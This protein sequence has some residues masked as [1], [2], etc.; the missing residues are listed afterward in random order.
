MNCRQIIITRNDI[1]ISLVSIS[2][3]GGIHNEYFSIDGVNYQCHEAEYETDLDFNPDDVVPIKLFENRDYWFEIKFHIEKSLNLEHIFEII[4]VKD[5]KKYL[6]KFN[7]KNYVGILN[8]ADF[9]I[10]SSIIEV[11]SKKID[12]TTAYNRLLKKVSELGIDLT[13]RAGSYFESPSR[14]SVDLQNDDA[15]LTSKLSYIRSII[16]TGDLEV[17]YNAFFRRPLSRMSS[18]SRKTYSWESGDIDI[19]SYISGLTD[20]SFRMSDG[21]IVP[22]EVDSIH[23]EDSVDTVENQFLKF[24]IEYIIDFLSEAY[25]FIETR[26]KSPLAAELKECLNRCELILSA[27]LFKD[28]SKLSYFPNKSNVLQQKYPYRDL[29]SLYWFLSQK[30]EVSDSIIQNS[31]KTPQKDLPTLYEYWCFLSMIDLLNSK[32]SPIDVISQGL[33]KYN[34]ETLSYVINPSD[35][36]LSYQIDAEKELKLFFNKT[37]SVKN[38]VFNGRSYS[39]LLNPDISLEYYKNGILIAIIHFDSKYRLENMQTFK[40]EDLNKM[41]AYKDGIIATI[42]A[43]VLY[44]GKKTKKFIQEEKGFER[45]DISFPSVGAFMFNIDENENI[46]DEKIDVV[47]LIDNFVNVDSLLRT[48]GL[49]TQEPKA[50]NYIRRLLE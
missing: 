13:T 15:V 23:F 32:Y 24:L 18:D 1:E 17:L 28:I 29:F 9:G 46:N 44:P 5:F 50:L 36:T 34:S 37:Y 27:P 43:Y 45:E 42:G 38:F 2:A 31:L 7:S 40:E 21:S 33:V 30:L 16:L 25:G 14:L 6:I 10:F 4:Q 19:D 48:E 47:N 3:G 49:F 8:L 35:C 39:H 22:L 26:R 11:Q 12:Y 20:S 41:H